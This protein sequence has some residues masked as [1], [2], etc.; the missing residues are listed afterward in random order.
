MPDSA[1]LILMALGLTVMVL[2]TLLLG[3]QLSA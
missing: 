3:C 1:L 2:C